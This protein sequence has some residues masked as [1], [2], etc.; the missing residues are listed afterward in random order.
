MTT[1]NPDN[2]L[3]I[4][5]GEEGKYEKECIEKNNTIK[6][7]Y[8]EIN[9]ELCISKKWDDVLNEVQ[10]KYNTSPG[11]TTGHRN[12]IRRFYE[13]PKTT[14]WITFYSNKL[15]YCYA[16]KDITFN[17]DG[18]K[19]RKAINGWKDS[20]VN[21]KKL[22]LQELSG[23]LTKVQGFQGTI[24][25]VKEKEYLIRKI[26]A[27]QSQALEDVEKSLGKLKMD[28]TKLIHMLTWKDFEEFT[29]LIF[30]AA[31]WARVGITGKTNKNIDIEM[32]AP[33][34]NERAIVQIKSESSL[35]TFIEYKSIFQGMNEYDRYFYVVHTPEADLKH[36]ISSDV[37]DSVDIYDDKRLAELCINAGLIEW[38]ISV[39]G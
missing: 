32:I 18:T 10:D 23:R 24:C 19:E 14:M 4:K 36:Y 7:G 1:H 9:H 5:L 30:K 28:L 29:E 26:N 37:E 39:V 38:L 17:I 16:D 34:I 35:K 6:I 3:Y 12:Q 25:D 33:V 8:R 22:F 13:E 20:D 15:W 11:K 31:G 2:I 27:K 21:G